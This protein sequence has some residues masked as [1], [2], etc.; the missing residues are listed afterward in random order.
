MS[1]STSAKKV[2]I[3]LIQTNAIFTQSKQNGTALIKFIL[4]RGGGISQVGYAKIPPKNLKHSQKSR[5][6]GIFPNKKKKKYMKKAQKCKYSKLY[7]FVFKFKKF[8]I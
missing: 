1:I 8:I 7:I 2:K 5:D 3:T 4:P 6:F